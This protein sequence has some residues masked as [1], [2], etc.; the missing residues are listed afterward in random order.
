[1]VILWGI[2]VP[3][4]YN[5]SLF[6]LQLEMNE[7]KERLEIEKQGWI[8]NYMKKQVGTHIARDLLLA[9]TLLHLKCLFLFCRTLCWWLKSVSWKRRSEKAVI[10]WVRQSCWVGF[11]AFP[12]NSLNPDKEKKT[13][14]VL[15]LLRTN[16]RNTFL[17]NSFLSLYSSL[18]LSFFL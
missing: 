16:W 12:P 6:D 11:G 2:S 7:L 3:G 15:H 5:W 10:G 17:L 18:F 4:N 1:M 14:I 9:A 8:E 13:Q